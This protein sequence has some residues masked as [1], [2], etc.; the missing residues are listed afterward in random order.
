[1]SSNN[2]SVVSV[3]SAM[4]A[5]PYEQTSLGRLSQ[6]LVQYIFEMGTWSTGE[7]TDS[8]MFPLLVSHVCRAWCALSR[9]TPT[10][11]TLITLKDSSPI[12]N[13]HLDRQRL[14]LS[15]DCS[16]TVY[17]DLRVPG[18]KYENED[19]HPVDSRAVKRM[20]YVLQNH[21]KRIRSFTVIADNF[22]PIHFTLQL[23]QTQ[24][25]PRLE[26]LRVERASHSYT[27]SDEF[28][29]IH[30]VLPVPSLEEANTVPGYQLQSMSLLGAHVDWRRWT[31]TNLVWLTISYL[32]HE[33]RPS[34]DLLR[35]V[36]GS[37]AHTLEYLE[38][39]GAA[40]IMRDHENYAWCPPIP[41]DARVSLPMLKELVLGYFEPAEAVLMITLFRYPAL[42]ALTLRDICRSLAPPCARDHSTYN[43]SLVLE[44]LCLRDTP[45]PSV[46]QLTLDGIHTEPISLLPL[47]F[48]LSFPALHSFS[49]K[50]SSHSFI[51][52]LA[53]VPQ[54]VLHKTV[55]PLTCPLL[56][57]LTLISMDACIVVPVL[58]WRAL[59]AETTPGLTS[60]LASVAVYDAEWPADLSPQQARAALERF[61]DAVSVGQ[62][63]QEADATSSSVDWMHWADEMGSDDE[64]EETDDEYLVDDEAYITEDFELG[65]YQP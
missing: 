1:M 19:A 40:P 35:A 32:P 38:I 23:L 3:S 47:H 56:R 27:T 24:P 50:D 18:W 57:V 54:T 34:I 20:F 26:C 10:L 44:T 46:E 6:D 12:P 60:R 9:A 11:W 51:A 64:D 16:L 33:D 37:C 48:L 41:T 58:Q 52:A 31:S 15:Q 65:P 55:P 7:H 43:A 49:V 30:L 8:L 22:C 36:I 53:L 61:A 21:L 4:Q 2:I 17:L 63:Y 5:L 62:G 42:K 45:I 28:F 25:M 14:R 29:P 39:Q 13:F 59:V